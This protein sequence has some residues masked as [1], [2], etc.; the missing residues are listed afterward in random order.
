MARKLTYV[1]I[2]VLL[3]V[4]FL[5]A[6]LLAF[7]LGTRTAPSPTPTPTPTPIPT[8]QKTPTPTGPPPSPTPTPQRLKLVMTNPRGLDAYGGAVH[9]I[10]GLTG[11]E[12]QLAEAES[13]LDAL[14][15][16]RDGTVKEAGVIY[17]TVAPSDM[18]YLALT[19][20][21]EKF[22]NNPASVSVMWAAYP[23]VLHVVTTAD[24]GIKSLADLRGKRVS[25]GPAGSRTEAQALKILE[26][27]RINP[28]RD[29]S[30]WERM[31]G[32]VAASYLKDRYIDAFFFSGSF[33][34]GFLE[35]LSRELAAKGRR[36]HLV[37]IDN[38]TARKYM[39]AFPGIVFQKTISK[40]TYHTT[41]DV[42]TLSTWD[43]VVCHKDLPSDAAYGI[44]RAVFENLAILHGSMSEAKH[45]TL[46]N[47]VVLHGGGLPYHEGAVRYYREVGVL[48]R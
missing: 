21:H 14:L 16:V 25:T 42:P 32:G 6:V 36:L 28:I 15:M 33:P 24:A 38:A 37:P 43:V 45:T 27:V 46:K 31:S 39:E 47:A 48:R 18:A 22:A 13:F 8:P 29:F 5:A 41:E 35:E 17:C 2:G 1:L 12:G 30:K 40:T 20:K 3:L 10:M 23:T 7:L 26:I 9:F 34:A 19:G 44:T 11:V 4:L